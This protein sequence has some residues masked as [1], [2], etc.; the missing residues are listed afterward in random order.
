MGPDATF[1]RPFSVSVRTADPD[2]ARAVCGDHLYP[3]S[4]RLVDPSAGLNAHFSFLHLGG[5][6]VLDVR[7][8]AEVAGT[9]G[10]FGNYHV[11]LP[12][13]GRFRARQ[14][15]RVLDGRP[16]QAAVYGPVGENVLD[17]ASADCHLLGL[18]I[19]T[20]SLEG[21]LAAALDGPVRGPLRLTGQLDASRPPGR[22][23]AQLIRLLAAEMGNPTGL[24]YEPIVAAPL[25]EG[26]LTALLFATDHQY[27]DQLEAG[28]PRATPRRAVHAIDAIHA[29]PRQPYT[30]AALARIA[31][32]STHGLRRE[33]HRRV[34]MPPMA[35]VREVRLAAAHAELLGA[36]PEHG[37]VAAIAQRWGFARVDRFTARYRARF[38]VTPATTL[39]RGAT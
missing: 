21:Q 11:N 17:H 34:G 32:M 16:G 13:A 35:Y 31:G 38:H 10:D 8:G 28:Q 2:E 18:K 7:Y 22:T 15:G 39:H 14:N 27:R 36:D 23:C 5:L 33:F 12:L 37:S 1:A 20:S 6:T 4:M 19:E 25:E 26:L 29:E 3:R 24:L 9:A 30:V